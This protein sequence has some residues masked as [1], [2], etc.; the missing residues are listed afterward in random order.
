M[1]KSK[2]I[3][4]FILVLSIALSLAA[5]VGC[6]NEQNEVTSGS[7]T[8]ATSSSSNSVTDNTDQRILLAYESYIVYAEGK[9]QTPLSYEE[10]LDSIKGAD[11][12][13]PTVEINTD[14]YWVINGVVSQYKA[15]GK[16]GKDGKSAYE[17]AVENGFKGSLSEWLESLIGA[18]GAQGI[19]IQNCEVDENGDLIIT[20]TNGEI[21]NAGKVKEVHGHEIVERETLAVEPTCTSV[22]LKY[23]FCETCGEFLK[24][25]ITDAIPHD[26]EDTVTLPTCTEQGYTTRIC[27]NCGHTEITDYTATI[28]HTYN[29]VVTLPTC[30]EQGYTTYT[31]SV[32]GDTY[33]A[34]YT[35]AD[36]T[37][38]DYV[39]KGEP[40]KNCPLS[41]YQTYVC[42]RC[43]DEKQEHVCVSGVSD[44][45]NTLGIDEAC[46][47]CGWSLYTKNGDSVLMKNS[48]DKLS[49]EFYGT[50][51]YKID[52]SVKKYIINAYISDSVTSIVDQA[53]RGCSSLTSVTIPDSVTSI[54]DNAFNSC[55]KLTSVTI[56]NG[57]TSIGGSAFSGCSSLTS[58]TIGNG[59]TSIGNSAFSNC[60]SLTSIVIPDS[61]TNI[62]GSAFYNCSGL[63]SIVIPDSVTS[64]GVGAF[65]YCDKVQ[66][67]EG[68]LIYVKNVLIGV[69]TSELPP[70]KYAIRQGTTIIAGQA[71]SGCGS[72]TS[73][74]IPDS[75]TSIGGDAFYSCSKLTSITIPESV[76]SIGNQAFFECSSL[77]SIT[78]PDSV[79]SIGRYA[80]GYCGSLTSITIPDSVTSIGDS[81]FYN[82]SSLESITLPFVGSSKKTNGDTYQYPFGYLFGR[83]S[84]FGRIGQYYYGSSTSSTTYE[85][86]DI[87]LSIKSVTITGGNILYG[88]FYNCSGLTNVTIGNGVTSIG[89]YAFYNC[90]GLTS[91]VIPDSVTSIG[92]DAFHNCS[93]LTKVI[94]HGTKAQWN[95]ISKGVDWKYN[96]PSSC[97]VYCMDEVINI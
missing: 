29:A 83:E 4:I 43:N 14:G 59:V 38:H 51:T 42:T 40:T 3:T 89:G 34:D 45:H 16:N 31:C 5:F 87:P 71:F 96:V 62:G 23:I 64:I 57:V 41:S 35:T 97:K 61:V 78:I 48:D 80:F 50:E 21:L 7:K 27:K 9:G 93:G 28:P 20:L 79:T 70:T 19:G 37:E 73:V 32:C 47:Y 46:E 13:T 81:V 26:Y 22:G 65:R 30:T 10:W 33:K 82:C 95:M 54:G 63:T 39:A 76:T 8:S 69:S 67:T 66:E 92:Y 11:G 72:L 52:D 53:F 58:V 36:S 68:G 88:A 84:Y 1:R 25:I 91:I 12:V 75:V 85:T 94:F 55:S 6:N 17:L 49:A 24:T 18:E 77:T 15:I 44:H 74:T 56:G 2:K 86:Y 90:S 60:S